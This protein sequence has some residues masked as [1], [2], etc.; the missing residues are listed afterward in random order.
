MQEEQIDVQAVLD[1]LRRQLADKS[2]ELAIANAR[3]TQV[4]KALQK[5]DKED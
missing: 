3:L 2:L 5:V 1:D 4:T